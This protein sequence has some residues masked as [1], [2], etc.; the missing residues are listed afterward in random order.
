MGKY[1]IQKEKIAQASRYLKEEGIDLWLIPTREGSDPALDLLTKVRTV[2]LGAFIITAGGTAMALTSRIDIQD[3]EESGLFE[4]VFTY[5][6]SF[7]DSLRTIIT[8]MNPQSIALNFS[9]DDHLCD[10]LGQGLYNL[11]TRSLQEVFSGEFVSS[12]K[13]LSKVRAVKSSEE[14]RCLKK[15]IEITNDI[16]DRVFTKIR[17]GMSEIEIGELFVDEMRAGN[18][19]NGFIGEMAPPMVLKERISHRKPGEAR[20]E[21]GDFFIIDFSISWEGYC[22]DIART[23][24]V[25]RKGEIDAPDA[26]KETFINAF[27]AISRAF[28]AVRPGVKGWEIDTIARSFLLEQGMPEITHATGHQIGLSTHD[29]GTLLGPKW[30]RYGSAPYGEIAEGMVFTLEPT[31]L[32]DVGFSA[33]VEENILVTGNGAEYLS[34]RQK[35]LYLIPYSESK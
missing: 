35:E 19:V 17:V 8:D 4:K 21:P 3:V 30:P 13:I 5:A 34:R 33:L 26:M 32:R 12:E 15:A 25:L 20:I 27:E 18:L 1:T 16:Y 10:G 14:I 7:E 24:Y 29:G 22:S 2:G 28:S 9:T 31:I 6:D 11:V 23:A